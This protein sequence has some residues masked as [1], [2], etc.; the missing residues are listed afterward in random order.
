MTEKLNSLHTKMSWTLLCKE[1]CVQALNSLKAAVLFDLSYKRQRRKKMRTI[2]SKLTVNRS[3]WSTSNRSESKELRKLGGVSSM[4]CSTTLFLELQVF[5]Y[6]LQTL[7]FPFDFILK[8]RF[9]FHK[10]IITQL[11]VCL[12]DIM[13]FHINKSRKYCMFNKYK[14]HP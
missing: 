9:F 3:K 10:K 6:V 8:N 1:S 13:G 14:N 11:I 7:A 5:F 12:F 4:S 2:S